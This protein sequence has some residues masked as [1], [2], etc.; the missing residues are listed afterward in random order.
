MVASGPFTGAPKELSSV[1]FGPS[2]GSVDEIASQL[3]EWTPAIRFTVLPDAA[4]FAAR[5]LAGGECIGWVE[6]RS[7]LGPRALGPR[8]ILADPRPAK[9]KDRINALVKKRESY[10]PFA[11]SVVAERIHEIFEVPEGMVMPFMVFNVLVRPE[12]RDRLQAVTHID[13]T[14]R[15]QGVTRDNN[16]RFHQLINTFGSITDVPVVLNTSFNN[17]A[18][19][20]VQSVDDA[21]ACFLTTGLNFIVIDNYLVE[22]H[23]PLGDLAAYA[24][25]TIPP[26]VELYVRQRPGHREAVL[27]DNYPGGR[28]AKI[29]AEVED[30]LASA[31]T[32]GS[33]RTGCALGRKAWA[34]LLELWSER[35][36]DIRFATGG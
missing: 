33:P 20:I 10:R 22:R 13:G 17:H 29:S 25:V 23:V 8:S 11:P 34:E 21:V 19:P 35:L 2:L 27:G 24:Q 18:E 6:G 1:F 3:S 16:P 31:Y 26:H 36:V 7:E 28:T 4:D 5:A 12:W 30:F 15:V 14:S 9:N 32:T